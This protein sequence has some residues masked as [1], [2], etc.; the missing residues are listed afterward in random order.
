MNP[1]YKNKSKKK[2]KLKETGSE[3]DF[4]IKH[5]KF[6]TGKNKERKIGAGMKK[7]GP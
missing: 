4:S 2:K 5:K 3:W 7:L 1:A 6:I